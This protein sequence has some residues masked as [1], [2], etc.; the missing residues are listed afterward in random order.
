MPPDTPAYAKLLDLLMLVYAG[1]RERTAAEYRD[2]LALAGFSM[3]AS[4]PR[5]RHQHHRGNAGRRPRPAPVQCLI[6]GEPVSAL[7]CQPL[8]DANHARATAS[9]PAPRGPSS[10]RSSGRAKWSAR[11]GQQRLRAVEVRGETRRG[12]PAANA[13]REKRTAPWARLRCQPPCW[14]VGIG[15]AVDRQ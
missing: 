7:P 11:R 15:H 9:S 14:L 13:G 6:R 5:L 8:G 4:C 12:D 1:G 2:L 3:N 10:R